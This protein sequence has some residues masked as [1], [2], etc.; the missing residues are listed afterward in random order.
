MKKLI[1]TLFALALIFTLSTPLMAVDYT[2]EAPAPYDFHQSTAYEIYH[3]SAYNYGGPNLAD[4]AD[5]TALLPG[6]LAP[7]AQPGIVTVGSVPVVS[8]Q[9]RVLSEAVYTPISQ[10]IRSDG[11]IGTVSIPSL[12]V[13]MKVYEGA[14]DQSMD[15]GLG[16]FSE[17]SGWAGNVAVSG[18]NRGAK[19]NIGVIKDMKPGDEIQYATLLGTRKYVVTFVGTISSDDWSYV[20]ASTD[21]RITL[22][23][24]LADRPSLRVCVQAVEAPR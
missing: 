17:S 4:I 1:A 10:L 9:T 24:C 11:S 16:H 3:G 6:I 2:F 15:K 21:N 5:H 23:T 20:A 8:M 18:H 12:S 19:Y 22:I 7:Q 14:T 13:S